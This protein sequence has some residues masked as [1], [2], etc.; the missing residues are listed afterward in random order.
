MG[1]SGRYPDRL[2]AC[3]ILGGAG[4]A[5]PALAPV[6]PPQ[7]FV[8]LLATDKERTLPE[9]RMRK[10]RERLLLEPGRG[11]SPRGRN[12]CN[13]DGHFCSAPHFVVTQE[14]HF[15]TASLRPAGTAPGT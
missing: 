8:I 4:A 13:S 1:I 3:R 7:K 2:P 6:Q 10:L 11:R 9:E 12:R 15:A 5:L 14:L